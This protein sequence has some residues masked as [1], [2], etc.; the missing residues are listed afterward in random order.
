MFVLVQLIFIMTD[1]GLEFWKKI[2]DRDYQV[3]TKVDNDVAVL[4]LEQAV[5]WSSSVKCI[6]LYSVLDP[7]PGTDCTFSGWG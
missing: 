5:Q 4:R 1:N 2:I 7:K 6:H 3:P